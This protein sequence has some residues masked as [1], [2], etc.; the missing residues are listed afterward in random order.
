MKTINQLVQWLKKKAKES[1]KSGFVVGLSG[2]VDSA[3]VAALALR[4]SQNL[5]VVIM[6][7]HSNPQDAKDALKFAKKFKIKYLLID[8][9][10]V[11]DALINIL[12]KS[13]EL[14]A[15]NLKS[16]LRMC[17]LYHIA[18]IKNALVLGTGNKSEA[19]IG[20]F[21]KY[22]DGG[23]DLMPIADF[24]KF[25]VYK[26]A[27]KLGVIREIIDKPPS[28]GLW[29][30]QTDESEMGITYKE[31]DGILAAF[32][33]GESLDKFNKKN[34]AKIMKMMKN[35]EHK[36]KTPEIFKNPEYSPF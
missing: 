1:G 10:T 34:A 33:N 19:S 23:V 6:P 14:T 35:S 32:Y 24:F 18:G 8:L 31:L 3:V 28:A 7:C 25:E 29:E 26:L 21:T 16:R 12:P 13:S 11:Y 2:G 9:S 15:A 17:V 27:E 4:A 5:T 22:G 36:R 20:Y 30:N